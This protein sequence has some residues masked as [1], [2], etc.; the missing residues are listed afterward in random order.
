M[1]DLYDDDILEWSERQA[2]LLRDV[3]EGRR[4]NEAPDW[5]NVIE[6]MESVGRSQLSAVKS[7]L[8]QALLHDLKS[9][10]WPLSRDVPHWQAEARGFRDE[11]ADAYAPSMRQ[12]IDV[13]ELYRR[14]LRRLPESLA[15]TPSVCGWDGQPPLPVPDVCPVTLEEPLGARP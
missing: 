6:E 2:R 1:G 5:A 13:A 4:G 7:L 15:E 3:A 8:V 14:A 12:H 9:V 11:A 10:A